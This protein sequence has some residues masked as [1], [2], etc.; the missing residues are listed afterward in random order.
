V[1]YWRQRWMRSFGRLP[2]YPTH[3]KVGPDP[4]GDTLYHACGPLVDFHRFANKHFK[5]LEREL[6]NKD[7]AALYTAEIVAHESEGKSSEWAPNVTG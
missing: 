3:E 5:E 1:T 4:E 6:G 2:V 7:V